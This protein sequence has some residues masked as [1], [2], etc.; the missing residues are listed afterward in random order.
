[1]AINGTV[2]FTDGTTQTTKFDSTD[3][4]GKVIQINSYTTAGTPK[5]KVKPKKAPKNQL[6][7]AP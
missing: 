7:V 1:M 4:Q 2:Q 5:Y 3:D 6:I